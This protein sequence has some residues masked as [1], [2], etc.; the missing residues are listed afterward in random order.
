MGGS[1]RHQNIPSCENGERL[2]LA[3]DFPQCWDGVNKWLPDESHVAYPSNRKCPDSH[4]KV[5]P[6]ITL[7][8]RYRIVYEGQTNNLMLSSDMGGVAKGS[9]A[10]AD[11]I[12]GWSPEISEKWLVNCLESQ[13]DCSANLLGE[14]EMLY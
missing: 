11:W 9:T 2:D 5:L 13:G 8:L 10:H 6:Q 14:G 12:N 4:P 3:V 1:T 7:N